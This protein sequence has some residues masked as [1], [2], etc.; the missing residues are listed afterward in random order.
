MRGNPPI[1][2]ACRRI[3]LVLGAALLAG[4][5]NYVPVERPAA[6]TV[7]RVRV[8]VTSAVADRNTPEGASAAI[9]GAVVAA[10]DSVVLAVERRAEYGAYREIVRHDTISIAFADALSVEE[11]IFSR[12]RSLVLGLGIAGVVTGLAATAFGLGGGQQGNVPGGEDPNRP[13]SFISLL[14]ISIGR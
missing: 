7:V 4:C 14:S 9:E 3:G 11:R 1:I 13:V 5:H 2:A 12:N 10:H 8:P 6:G